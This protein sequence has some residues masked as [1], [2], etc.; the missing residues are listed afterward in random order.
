MG[1]DF[2]QLWK[3]KAIISHYLQPFPTWLG[4]VRSRGWLHQQATTHSRLAPNRIVSSD[5]SNFY[6]LLSM[7]GW[8]CVCVCVWRERLSC[9]LGS[10]TQVGRLASKRPCSLSHLAGSFLFYIVTQLSM[11]AACYHHPMSYH[12]SELLDRASAWRIG[13]WMWRC[14]KFLQIYSISESDV[15][16]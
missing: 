3:R 4:T 1:S 13:I 6:L 9:F 8:L 12:G 5:S 16:E 7:Y 14:L 2:R 10:E 11:N 15:N